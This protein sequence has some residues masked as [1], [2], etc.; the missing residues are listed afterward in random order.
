MSVLEIDPS[1]KNPPAYNN[2]I[3]A[4]DEDPDGQH[5]AALI[6]NFFHKWF[7]H[8][9]KEGRLH[10]LTTP[11]VVCDWKD[12]RK[13][14]YS[15]EEFQKFAD[16]KKLYGVNYLK[17][18]GSLD[19]DDWKWVMTNKLLFNIVEDRSANK[20]LDIAFGDSSKKRK[21]WLEGK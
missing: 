10:K 11:L 20:F 8:I 15:L 21:E 16:K 1:R 3:I 7:P 14:F 2:I 18:L 9:I 12:G 19:M 6:I 17:G 4:A 13:Y 5:I